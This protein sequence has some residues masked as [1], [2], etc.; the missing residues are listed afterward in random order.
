MIVI[1]TSTG[2]PRALQTV[3]TGLPVEIDAPI[4]IVQHMP[5]G[6]TK[7]LATRL[8]LFCKIKVR[9]ALPDPEFFDIIFSALGV[10]PND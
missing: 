7:S 10:S 9:E 2:G 4:L 8:N 6:F 5:P 1:G 3:L